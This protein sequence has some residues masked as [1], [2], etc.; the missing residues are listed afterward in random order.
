MPK[1]LVTGSGGFIG[2]HTT[3]R[4]LQDG[5]EVIG[6]D[7]LNDYYDPNLKL[8]RLE[9]LNSLPDYKNKFI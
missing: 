6:I 8:K 9:F 5:Y 1:I 4:L 7:N 3:K 2:F